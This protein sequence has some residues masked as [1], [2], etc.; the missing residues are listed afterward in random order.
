MYLLDT[1]ICIYIIK[2]N[3]LAVVEKIKSLQP[4]QIKLSAISI[5]ELEYGAAKSNKR[6]QNRIALLN[7]VSSF[8]ILPFNENDAEYYGQI[9]A[10]L[11]K[12]GKIIGAYDMQIAAQALSN[13]LIL[14]TNNIREFKRIPDIKLG[15][16]V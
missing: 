7:F 4:H 3:P 8:D 5:A 13:N 2:N 16:W 15:D 14:I 6:D 10:F 11:E 1:N 9:R 12:T